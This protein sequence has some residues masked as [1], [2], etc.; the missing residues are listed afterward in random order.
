MGGASPADLPPESRTSTFTRKRTNSHLETQSRTKALK[1]DPATSENNA[2]E[3]YVSLEDSSAAESEVGDDEQEH[4]E[5]LGREQGRGGNDDT[6]EENEDGGVDSTIPDGTK[7]NSDTVHGTP[8][9]EL[10]GPHPTDHDG[11]ASD[12]EGQISSE[13]SDDSGAGADDPDESEQAG[14]AETNGERLPKEKTKKE[15]RRERRAARREKKLLRAQQAVKRGKRIRLNGGILDLPKGE[16]GRA[17][18]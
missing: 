3:D 13:D 8:G 15:L 4:E 2:S 1:C 5:T 16:I 6:E 10:N 12:G 18:V 9:G 14:Q 11:E 17:H 7:S